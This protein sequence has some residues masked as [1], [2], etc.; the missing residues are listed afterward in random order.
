MMRGT[1]AAIACL[2]AV[3]CHAPDREP[4]PPIPPTGG[5]APTGLLVITL[6]TTR[7]DRIGSY[8]HRGASTPNI[9]GLGDRGVLFEVALTPVPLTTP[10]HASLWTGQQP[11]HHGV[12]TNEDVLLDEANLTLAEVLRENG[13]RTAAFV[14]AAVLRDWSGLDQGFETYSDDFPFDSNPASFSYAEKRAEQVVASA[15]PWLETVGDD[16]YFLWVHLFDPHGPYRPPGRFAREFQKQPYDGEIAY[17]DEQI[18]VLLEALERL[19][20]DRRTL[21]AFLSDHGEGLGEHGEIAHGFFLYETTLRIPF[22]LSYPPGLPQRARV[23]DQVRITDLMPTALGLLELDATLTFAGRDLRPLIAG[24]IVDEAPAYAETRYPLAA[25]GWSPTYSLRRDGWKLIRAPLPEL[26][27]LN[28][29]PQERDNLFDEESTR[30]NE[31]LAELEN[32]ERSVSRDLGDRPELDPERL[33]ALRALGYVGHG[34]SRDETD[35]PLPDA[36]ERIATLHVMGRA[37]RMLSQGQPEEALAV[38]DDLA[39][40]EPDSPRVLELQGSTLLAQREFDRARG[41]YLRILEIDPDSGKAL[42]N[43]GLLALSAGDVDSAVDL[44]E[45]A[46]DVMPDDPLILLNLGQ[47]YFQTLGDRERGRAHLERYLELT[48]QDRSAEAVRR[49]LAAD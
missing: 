39:R 38:L 26:Y 46:R 29:D 3:A 19:E 9:D 11:P 4:P 43:L 32:L 5:E 44:L 34:E 1:L 33:A 49:L 21:V 25:H 14:G 47:V 6:D 30:A 37:R 20:L 10:A 16:A 13:F 18:G 15:I 27:D 36:K 7:A 12:R 35:G 31:M 48:P 28:Q 45:R 41:V 17:A 24:A 8:G 42:M 2:A 40:R 23:P 22:I